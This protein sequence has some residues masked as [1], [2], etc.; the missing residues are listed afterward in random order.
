MLLCFLGGFSSFL[1][2]SILRSSQI[3]LL[4]SSG[5]MMSSMKPLWAATMGLAK[6][7]V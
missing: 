7:S 2:S 3:I 1:L 4:V 6:R 5:S